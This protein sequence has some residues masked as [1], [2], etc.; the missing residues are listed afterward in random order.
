LSTN[1]QHTLSMHTGDHACMR[2][3]DDTLSFAACRPWPQGDFL[4]FGVIDDFKNWPCMFLRVYEPKNASESFVIDIW[5]RCVTKS[6]SLRPCVTVSLRTCRVSDVL[7]T[8]PVRS[9]TALV[10][11][12][13]RS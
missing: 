2:S 1:K 5:L 6:P 8:L 11:C 13:S 7:L 12:V 3:C 4:W 10:L 9:H